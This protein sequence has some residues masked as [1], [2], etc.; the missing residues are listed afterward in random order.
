MA[1]RAINSRIF[2][3]IDAK[4]EFS[5][6]A[7]EIEVV[8]IEVDTLVTIKSTDTTKTHNILFLIMK[9]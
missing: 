5:H 8:N 4:R 3:L 2:A 1:T 9:L 7:S 6:F